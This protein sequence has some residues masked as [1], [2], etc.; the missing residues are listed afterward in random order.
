MRAASLALLLTVLASPA[1]ADSVPPDV[2]AAVKAA[3]PQM[4]ITEAELKERDGRRYYDV[5]GKLP[6]GAEIELDML[7]TS[8]GWEVVEIQRDIAWS[9]APAP[10]RAA[11]PTARPVRV[12]ESRQTDGAVVY[13]LFAEGQPKD[14]ALEVMWKDGQATVLENRWPH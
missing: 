10:V 12:I 7:Q 5:E 13:E 8:R 9:A 14:P 11:A 2:A 4:T 6:D 3:M 1:L